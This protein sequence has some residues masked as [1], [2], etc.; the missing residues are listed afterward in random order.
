[1]WTHYGVKGASCPQVYVGEELRELHFINTPITL[2]SCSHS[3]YF[4]DSRFTILATTLSPSAQSIKRID[5]TG[6]KIA[7][8]FGNEHRG[9][10]RSMEGKVDGHV[11]LPMRGFAQSF[12]VSV[13][14]ASTLMYLNSGPWHECPST[15]VNPIRDITPYYG[16][17]LGVGGEDDATSLGELTIGASG[18]TKI[19]RLRKM[20]AELQAKQ[21]ARKAST[22]SVEA[23][24]P[25]STKTTAESAPVDPPPVTGPLRF[26]QSD[27]LT[28]PVL[29][30][31]TLSAQDR[32]ELLARWLIRSHKESVQILRRAG[33]DIDE[34]FDQEPPC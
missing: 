13:A 34:I 12:N 18:E 23:T 2:F 26:F 16:K 29:H 27:S 20:K 17:P 21:A 5:L 25:E 8:V 19:D 10:S 11:I 30:P 24:A 28:A 32:D 22:A 6:R 14:V 31:G 4:A 9:V 3:L 15:V 1:M 7:V 33:I